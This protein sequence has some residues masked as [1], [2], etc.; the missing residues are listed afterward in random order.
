MKL[1]LFFILMDV[2]ILL[3]YPIVY[4]ISKIRKSASGRR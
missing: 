2:L 1:Y 4:V 3:S